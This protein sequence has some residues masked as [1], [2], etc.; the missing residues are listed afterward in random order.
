MYNILDF[1]AVGDGVSND[2]DAIQKTIDECIKNGGS[3]VYFPSGKTYVCGR[4]EIGS[5][6]NLFLES[7]CVL[8]ASSNPY[9]FLP[10]GINLEGYNI[11][12]GE[13]GTF[14]SDED[15]NKLK[16]LGD[17]QWPIFTMIY[18]KDSDNI[19]ITGTGTVDGNFMAFVDDLDLPYHM[20]SLNI[21]RPTLVYFEN[22]SKVL[23]KDI[24]IKDA[25]FWT[26]HMAGCNNV[27]INGI[28]IMNDLKMA[29]CDGIDI[30]HCKN[31]RITNCHIV[32]A[33]DAIC[34]KNTSYLRKYGNLENIIISNCTL[35]S[36]SC[37]IK[38][39][40][41]SVNDFLN[42]LISDCIISDSNRA[43]GFQ[44]RDEGNIKNVKVSNL[45]I[46]TRRFYHRY[47]GKAEPIYIT[48]IDR[49][50]DKKSGYI[51][52][53]S[54]NN[55]S[56]Y[57]E[58]GIF[59]YSDNKEKIANISFDNINIEL[60]KISKWEQDYCDV[61]PCY[62]R[63]DKGLLKM[64]LNGLYVYNAKSIYVKNMNFKVSDKVK[65][66]FNKNIMLENVESFVEN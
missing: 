30:D 16:S 35:T 33:D 5:N 38:F 52:D 10:K 20:D 58:N 6:I 56:S 32:S 37:S 19:S 47:W 27:L 54:F 59:I 3:T 43:I 53:I 61:R 1:G 22:C 31:V 41:E 14:P 44:L 66:Y 50:K 24:A 64:P 13:N 2:T 11:C 48:S 7:G 25:P 57:G 49:Q 8:K 26:V 18:S 15:I 36:T 55:I 45:I 60:E 65:S 42:I 34:L 29:N 40:S 39:G 51:E 17:Y 9:D 46:K 12:K 23:L 21:P 28:S 62:Y 4:I 63:E